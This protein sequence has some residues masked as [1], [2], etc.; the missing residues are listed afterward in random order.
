MRWFLTL[1]FIAML[2]L[3]SAAE[4]FEQVIC[5]DQSSFPNAAWKNKYARVVNKR[6]GDGVLHL[7]HTGGSTEVSGRFQAGKAN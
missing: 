1:L 3:T 4:Q 7:R 6:S 5:S 2:I